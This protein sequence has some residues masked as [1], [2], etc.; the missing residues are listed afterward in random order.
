MSKRVMING[1]EVLVPDVIV[2]GR[3]LKVL[4]EIPL[5]RNLVRQRPEGNFL[6]ANDQRLQV[7]DDDYFSDAPT[8]EYGAA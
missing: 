4:G 5:D 7:L 3:E 1:R 8:F 6:V 2:T